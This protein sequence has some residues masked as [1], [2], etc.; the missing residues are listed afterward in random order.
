MGLW[1]PRVL[2]PGA[3]RRA[4]TRRQSVDARTPVAG[5]VLY[6]LGAEAPPGDPSRHRA[7]AEVGAAGVRRREL[8]AD[9]RRAIVVP[10]HRPAG[11]TNGDG[12]DRARAYS[13]PGC[14]EDRRLHELLRR[15]RPPVRPQ[16]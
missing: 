7:E 5:P 15:P 10:D 8:H 2:A 13:R 4:D 11:P 12:H 9:Q 6:V 1:R 3:A 14:A 16:L